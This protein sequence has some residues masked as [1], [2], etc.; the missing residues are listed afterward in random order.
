MDN[1]GAAGGET[2]ITIVPV[3]P[4][5]VSGVVDIHVEAFRSDQFSNLMLLGRPADAYRGLMIK[6]IDHWLTDP[7]TQLVRAVDADGETLGWTCWVVK[8]RTAGSD[9]KSTTN[10][11]AENPKAEAQSQGNQEI[12]APGNSKKQEQQGQIDR[13]TDPAK[14]L[15][16]LMRSDLERW[17]TQQMG[18]GKYM[19][20]QALATS[21]RCQGRGIGAQL[22]QW[23]ID[24]ADADGLPCWA[25]A[26]PPGYGLYRRAGFEEV[27]RSDYDLA[28]WAPGGKGGNRGWGTYT[29]RYMV[30]PAR[31]KPS[32][33]SLSTDA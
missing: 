21:P 12:S 5:D 19:V 32:L 16:G 22:V 29:F 33:S 18:T 23:G 25:H 3:G 24:K 20:L 15:S 31:E 13:T 2:G 10:P 4:Q 17:E 14:V 28:T 9:A 26:S 30:R 8:S 1:Q 6:S 11:G 7:A 27:G